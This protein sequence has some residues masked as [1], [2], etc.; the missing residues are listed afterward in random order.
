MGHRKLLR[1]EQAFLDEVRRGID[2]LRN[3]DKIPLNEICNAL[4]R[5]GDGKNIVADEA[6]LLRY[7]VLGELKRQNRKKD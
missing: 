6:E 7:I 1:E 5:I 4:G 2:K 3:E